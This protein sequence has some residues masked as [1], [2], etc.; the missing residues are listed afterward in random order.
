MKKEIIPIFFASDDNYAKQLGVAMASLMANASKRFE[1]Q[2]YVLHTNISAKYQKA[3]KG[4]LKDGFKLSF[5]D[6]S[7]P[8]SE[9]SSRLYMRDYYTNTTYFRFFIPSLFPQYHK[10]LYLDADIVIKGDIS[11]L[12]RFNLSNRLVGAVREE[13]MPLSESLNAY[14]SEVIGIDVRRYFNAG[15]LVMNLDE[16]RNQKIYET[17]ISLLSTRKFPLAQDQDYLNLMCQGQ[18]RYLPLGWNKTPIKKKGFQKQNLYLAHFKIAWKPWHQDG[19]LFGEY[20][21]KYAKLTPFY[22]DLVAMRDNYSPE[23]LERDWAAFDNLSKIAQSEIDKARMNR[24]Y[25][26]TELQLL[27]ARTY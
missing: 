13:V 15:I 12:Y 2:M 19:I 5:V 7:K 1:Y 21:W 27:G 18:V 8:L 22:D 16:F 23:Q 26:S 10:A 6:V 24:E 9:F 25:E 3:L 14:P 17:F 11:K 4:M 20:F